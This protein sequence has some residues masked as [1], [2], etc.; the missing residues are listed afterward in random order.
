MTLQEKERFLSEA[1]SVIAQLDD[2]FDSHEFIKKYMILYTK[3]YAEM[4]L[5]FKTFATTHGHI[6]IE[7]KRMSKLLKINAVG[8]KV[9]PDIFNEMTEC[10]LWFNM[11]LNKE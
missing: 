4:L 10:E 7:L 9:S 5:K 1:Q 11:N 8:K 6:A 3:S 2:E